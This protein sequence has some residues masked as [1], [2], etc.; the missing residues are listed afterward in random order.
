MNIDRKWYLYFLSAF[1]FF[2]FG[3]M[4]YKMSQKHTRRIQGYEDYRLFWH[5]S[6]PDWVWLWRQQELFLPEIILF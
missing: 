3:L 4:F 2:L 1:V 6:I 5:F